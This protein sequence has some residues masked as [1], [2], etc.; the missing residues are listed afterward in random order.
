[1]KGFTP[2]S[3]VLAGILKKRRLCDE[4]EFL[5]I[6]SKWEEIVG[7]RFAEHAHPVR[8]KKNIL[9]VEVKDPSYLSHMEYMKGNLMD[10]ITD[11]IGKEIGDVKFVLSD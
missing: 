10:K 11:L 5:K 6:F 2:I 4:M 3:E 8:I 7:K 1:M 9:Y